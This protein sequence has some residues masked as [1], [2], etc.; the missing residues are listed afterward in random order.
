MGRGVHFLPSKPIV[1]A[2][3]SAAQYS[4]PSAVQSKEA[5]YFSISGRF[6]GA[7]GTSM[8]AYREAAEDT[9]G[10]ELGGLRGVG[11]DL[12]LD[13]EAAEGGVTAFLALKLL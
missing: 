9:A 13:E 6:P 10:G 2:L 5:S 12:D 3:A 4:T 7:G 8:V 1:R 11:E